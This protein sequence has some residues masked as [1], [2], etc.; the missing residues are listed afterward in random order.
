MIEPI[1]NLLEVVHLQGPKNGTN[2]KCLSRTTGLPA[3][4]DPSRLFTMVAPNMKITTFSSILITQAFPRFS[5]LHTPT[6]NSIIETVHRSISQVIRT[7]IHLLPPPPP[8][9]PRKPTCWLTMLWL[10]RCMLI[11]VPLTPLL[12]FTLQVHLCFNVTCSSTFP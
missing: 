4:L 12:A 6:A 1:S 2:T 7:L 9:R 10:P 8:R 3:I 5:F 11:V